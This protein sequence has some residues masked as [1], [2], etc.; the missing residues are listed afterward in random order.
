MSKSIYAKEYEDYIITGKEEALNSLV[1]TSIEKEYFILIR[2]LLNEDL[3]P[4]LQKK[5]D[6]FVKSIDEEQ[7]Y[8]LK[9]LNI[10]KKLQKNPENKSEIIKNIKSLFNLEEGESQSKPYKY[11]KHTKNKNEDA[12]KESEKLPNSLDLSNYN[13]I[14]KFIQDIYENKL[15]PNDDEFQKIFNYEEYDLIL[16]F[17]KIPEETIVNILTNLKNYSG[18]KDSFFKSLLLSKIDYFKKVIKLAI[19]KCNDLKLLEKDFLDTIKDNELLLLNEQIE[20]LLENKLFLDCNS[21]INELIY[22]KINESSE[23]KN[24]IDQYKEAR[25]LI[26]KYGIKNDKICRV[27]LLLLLKMYCQENIYDLD[28]FIEY[29]KFP[30]NDNSDFYNINKDL[31]KKIKSL[32]N[33]FCYFN[34]TVNEEKIIIEKCLKHFFLKKKIE[35]EK[36][37]KYFNETFIK[38][39]YAKMQF[40]LGNEEYS[41]N[42]I[43]TSSEI[44]YLMEEI[45]LNICDYNKKSF[46][47]D[48]DI[49]LI[50]EIKN[51][52]TLFVNI[53]EINTENYYYSNKNKFEEGI[54]LDGIIPT[55]EDIYSYNEKPQLLIEKK[56]KITKIPK[57]RGLYVIEFIGNGHVSR[58][59]IQKGNLKCIHK[60][61]INGKIFYIIDEENKICKGEKT[62]I[63]LNDVWYPSQKETG[64]I[65]I[66]YSVR[67]NKIIL[68]HEDFCSI[69]TNI[70]IPNEEYELSCLFIVNKESFIM[71]NVTKVLV[72]PYLLVCDE[73]CPLEELKNVKLTIK[74]IKIE[75]NQKIPSINVIDNI[76]LS[77]NKEFSFE[78]QVPP[79]LAK[80]EFELYAE[81]QPKTKKDIKALYV[82]KEF[83]FTRQFEYDIVLKQNTEGNYFAYIIGRNGEP[84]KNHEIEIQIKNIHSTSFYEKKI[85]ME[86]DSEGKIDLGKLENISQVKIGKKT[87]KINSYSRFSYNRKIKILENQEIN[88]PIIDDKFIYL[89]KILDE[90]HLENLTSLIKIKVTD[91]KKNLRNL[92]IPKLSVGEYT[93]ILNDSQIRIDVI[94]GKSM[95]IKGFIIDDKGNIIYNKSNDTPIAIENVTY[96]NKE[97]KIKLN[98]N[99]KDSAHP[100][101]HIN[102]VQYRPK[103][104][105][106]NL[107]NFLESSFYKESNFEKMKIFEM[108]QK[109]NIYLNN[110]IL[111]DEM[112]YILDRKQYNITLGNSLEKPSLLLKPQIIR[113][114]NTEIK[115]GKKGRG[116]DRDGRCYEKCCCSKKCKRSVGARYR[117]YEEEIN[118]DDPNYIFVHD[119]LNISPLIKDNLIPDENGEIILKDIDLKD[120]SFLNILCFDKNSCSE[121]CFYLKNGKTS[122]RDLRAVSELDLNKNY[123]EFRRLYPLSKNDKHHI[124][125]IT[126]IKYKIFDSLEKYVEFIKIVNSSLQEDLKQ[127]EFLLNFNNLSLMEK[128]DKT[129]KYFCHEV[130]VYLYFHHNDFFNHYIYPILKYKS[131]KT[132]IDY[133]LLDDK[134]KILE[135]V[136]KQKINELNAFEKCLLI[137]SI[138]KNNKT[139]SSVSH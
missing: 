122:L 40:Y 11:Q 55:Y 136:K 107:M 30:A 102:A 66:P 6:N 61:T 18:I 1:S 47:A 3:T 45:I 50:L 119:F 84:K 15:D 35:F 28:L 88:L 16:D 70:S 103:I 85:L 71:G 92:T 96:N 19:D 65:L 94:R 124:K 39:F 137:Y 58:A 7:A 72:R 128:L 106:E 75:N 115:E 17:N 95:D 5:I 118:Y 33:E 68:K 110:K 48:E 79:K 8:R 60:N 132:F 91:E 138:R 117:D 82:K 34:V 38:N 126:S 105:N 63:W 56:I 131:E 104:F 22:R 59:I 24:K 120:Y 67:G 139:L 83:N 32:G 78:F 41:N 31:E 52:K 29:I 43:L 23:I 100:R 134:D 112:Q 69:E 127:F 108:S 53:Y 4:E 42:K 54:S 111:S 135:Y 114:T 76:K 62:G 12:V 89:I 81:I 44:N 98:K 74:S 116:Y 73:I 130:N 113:D 129:S 93:L 121:D 36:F 37:H 109:E 87:F 21:L 26:E 133:F 101:V 57:K 86:T 77:Y 125:D 123:C 46:N 27:I 80:I 90:H 97:L 10:F 20:A 64:A 9:A 2:R 14:D 49:E 51:I 99:N 25:K 13:K